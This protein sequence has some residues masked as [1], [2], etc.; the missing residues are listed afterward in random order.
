MQTAMADAGYKERKS[1]APPPPDAFA[2]IAGLERKDALV[3]LAREVFLR[4]H[5]SR[6]AAPDR[7]AAEAR[8]KDLGLDREACATAFGN[9]LDV[10]LRGPE[11]DAEA[12]LAGALAAHVAALSDPSDE[13]AS[14]LA[15]LLVWLSAHT[16][17]D[18]LLWVDSL[19]ASKRPWRAIADATKTLDRAERLVVLAALAR[20]KDD[21]ARRAA[22][23]ASDPLLEGVARA[24][25]GSTLSFSGRVVRAPRRAW[26]T[27]LLGMTGLLFVIGAVRLIARFVLSYRT[28]ATVEVGRDAVTVRYKVELLGRTLFDRQV[29][30]PREGLVHAVRE[31]RYPRLHLYTGLVMLAIGTWLG[32]SL[33]V[34][35]VRAW[36]SSLLG[37]GLLLV[38]AGI[39]IDFLLASI[40][41]SARGKCRVILRPRRG[42][43]LAIDDADPMRADMA[44]GRLKS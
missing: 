27:I 29:V 38:V 1:K 19:P 14:K 36:S 35:G 39:G 41:P 33:V 40:I 11:D 22:S 32:M 4:M 42:A 28:P 16:P 3:A 5:E 20:S 18:A 6:R 8:A 15:D 37:V 23:Q 12:R 44:L 2:A 24:A 7:S 26:A 17:F 43:A 13:H 9:A 25:D 21:I 31:V 34:D 10:L 30:V